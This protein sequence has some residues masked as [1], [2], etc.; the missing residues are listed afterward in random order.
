MNDPTLAIRLRDIR[1]TYESGAMKVPVLHGITLDVVRGEYVAV[2]GPSGSGKSTLMNLIGCL[3]RPT[4]GVYVL[5]GVDVSKL[6]DNALAAIRLQKLGFVFQGFNLLARTDALKNVALPLFYAGVP[7]RERAVRAAAALEDVGLGDRGHHQ[8]SQLSGGQQQ[9]V[10]I[11]RALIND[12][13][14]LL[15][16]EPTGNLDSK[17]SD[18][19]MAL[20]DKLHAG[21]RTIIMVTHDEAI[22]RNARRIVRLLDGLVVADVA[23][24]ATA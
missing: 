6:D 21:G 13:A 8:P 2:M 16:D 17:T 7:A 19:I 3:D 12:P 4:S 15:A 22:A 1:K 11:A 20:F 14:V 24:G 9:R 18:D 23:V 5:D 10:A